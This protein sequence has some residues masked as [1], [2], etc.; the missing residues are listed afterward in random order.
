MDARSFATYSRADAVASVIAESAAYRRQALDLAR[1][2]VS[3]RWPSGLPVEVITAKP[4]RR[5]QGGRRAA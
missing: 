2:R 5:G 3:T 1:V 4:Q